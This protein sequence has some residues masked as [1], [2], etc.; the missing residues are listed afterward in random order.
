MKVVIFGASGMIGTGVLLE[1][2][3]SNDVESVCV[4][5]RS[6]SGMQ[7]AKLREIQHADFLDFAPIRDELR[8]VDACFWCLGVSSAG[9]SEEEYTR[10]TYGYTKAAAD[11]LYELNP[12]LAFCFVSGASTDSTEAG[13]TMWARVKGKAE[14]LVLGKGFR[15]AVMFRPGYIH[16]MRGTRSKTAV[17][18]I[19]Y[20]FTVPLYPVLRRLFPKFVT[21]SVAIGRAMIVAARDGSEK[22]ILDPPDINALAE[23]L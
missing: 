15:R 14:N 2:L 4:V 10:I 16:P 13:S 18:R 6:G 12:Q 17:Y 22:A 7:H 1:C 8:D 5:G 19:A 9:L 20:F 21:T 23:Q 11:L 3:D